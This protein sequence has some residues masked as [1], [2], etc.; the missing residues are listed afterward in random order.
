MPI[1]ISALRTYVSQMRN[2]LSDKTI[3]LFQI[4]AA[5]LDSLALVSVT[6]LETVNANFDFGGSKVKKLMLCC[7][8]LLIGFQLAHAGV[9]TLAKS[10]V[11][12][13]NIIAYANCPKT[14]SAQTIQVKANFTDVIGVDET[15]VTL[16]KVNKIFLAPGPTFRVLYSNACTGTNNGVCGTNTGGACL[17]LPPTVA[18][19][20]QVW[21]RLVGPPDSTIDPYLCAVDPGTNFIVCDSDH[22]LKTRLTG[23]GEPS[24][25]NYTNVLLKFGS[26]NLF[27]SSLENYFWSW[28]TGGKPHAQVWFVDP[29]N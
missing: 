20:F 21:V 26:K 17:Q 19:D 4:D 5:M 9:G 3:F 2:C 22:I 7:L 12:S 18:T 11:Y 24:F 10:K 23:K 14:T 1:R 15:L 13:V 25:T 8:I 6:N 28:N 29:I 27:D 16:D